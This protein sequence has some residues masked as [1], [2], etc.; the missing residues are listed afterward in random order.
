MVLLGLSLLTK[1]LTRDH[2]VRARAFKKPRF[3]LWCLHQSSDPLEIVV[4]VLI[5]M[6]R[7]IRSLHISGEPMSDQQKRSDIARSM[8]IATKPHVSIQLILHLE[9]FLM[10]ISITLRCTKFATLHTNLEINFCNLSVPKMSIDEMFL[11]FFK[12]LELSCCSCDSTTLRY[13]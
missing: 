4:S 7:C 3:E 8:S 6:H 2:A 10:H 13:N 9:S 5:C 1:P 11:V 12:P